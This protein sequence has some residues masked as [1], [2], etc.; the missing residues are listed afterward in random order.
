M[1]PARSVAWTRIFTWSPLVNGGLKEILTLVLSEV[2]VGS[3]F[4]ISP[5]VEAYSTLTD[6]IVSD[7]AMS[8][9]SFSKTLTS[10]EGDGETVATFGPARSITKPSDDTTFETLSRAS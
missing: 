10:L 3:I 4:K 7:S 9:S 6:D 5:C 8:T 2:N 1:L